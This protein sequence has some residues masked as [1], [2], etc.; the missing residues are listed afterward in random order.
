MILSVGLSPAWQQIL[1]FDSVQT[2]QVNRAHTAKWCA[3]G[4]VFNAAIAIHTL[5]GSG[6][7]MA[8]VGGMPQRSMEQELRALGMAYRLVKSESTTR[9]CTTIIDQGS[10]SITE[11]VEEG[12][13][14]SP[15]ELDVFQSVY[16]EEVTQAGVV[17]MMGSLPQGVPVSFY[18]QLLEKSACPMV[19]D[20]R[21]EGLLS[22]LDLEPLVVKPNREELAKTVE[23]ALDQDQILMDAMLSLN[24]QGAKWVVVT[25]GQEPVWLSSVS[26]VYRIWPCNLDAGE[27]VNPIGSGDAMAGTIAWAVENGTSVPDAVCLGVAA[28]AQNIRALLPC[29]LDP[30]TLA[31]EAKA[32]RVERVQ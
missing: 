18:R 32:I 24:Q 10:G 23:Y 5:G 11:L 25:G 12:R 19:L 15:V 9:V 16:G 30:S 13:P 7:V 6:L 22:V 26:E 27:I 17:V 8:P 2:G 20:F 21:G 1:V 3:S 29:R 31:A 28:A 14:L 4:K